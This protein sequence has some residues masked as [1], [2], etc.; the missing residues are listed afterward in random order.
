MRARGGR[1]RGSEGRRVRGSEGSHNTELRQPIMVS[2]FNCNIFPIKSRFY[3]CYVRQV[4]GKE[5]KGGGEE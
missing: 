1:V 3:R 2:T 4:R 5:G